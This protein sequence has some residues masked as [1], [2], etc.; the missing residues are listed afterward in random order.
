[1]KAS[2]RARAGSSIAA[3][4]LVGRIEEKAR[5]YRPAMTLSKTLSRGQSKRKAITPVESLWVGWL[6]RAKLSTDRHSAPDI[7]KLETPV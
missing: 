7:A 1:M 4:P 6:A 5:S 2:T 3:L